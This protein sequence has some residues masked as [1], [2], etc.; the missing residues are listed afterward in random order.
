MD[1]IRELMETFK[2][3]FL[4]ISLKGLKTLKTLKIFI[5]SK[6][7]PESELMS[8]ISEKMT[9][10]KSSKLEIVNK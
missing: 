6:D 8:P 1:L 4:L 10:K 5:L 3:S 7:P 9:I 2:S